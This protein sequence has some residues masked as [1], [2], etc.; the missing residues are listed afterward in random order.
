MENG[1]PCTGT[2]VGG[3]QRLQ[4]QWLVVDLGGTASGS[5]PPLLLS[6]PILG[7]RRLWTRLFPS[8]SLPRIST[9]QPVPCL[10][11]S[12]AAGS[13]A[14][15]HECSAK[16]QHLRLFNARRLAPVRAISRQPDVQADKM[17]RCDPGCRH[18]TTS[19]SMSMSMSLAAGPSRAARHRNLESQ[20]FAHCRGVVIT[21]VCPF[22]PP[23]LTRLASSPGLASSI[24]HFGP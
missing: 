22:P 13:M 4:V 1:Q 8:G 23:P 18:Q 16:R 19:M 10:A 3:T 12:S 11:A 21:V 14:G 17:P 24:A 6:L 7:R 2:S 15:T 5:G 9:L 20:F